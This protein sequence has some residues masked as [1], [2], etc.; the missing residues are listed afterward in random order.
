MFSLPTLKTT[1]QPLHDADSPKL[2]TNLEA[3]EK[4]EHRLRRRAV[5][6]MCTFWIVSISASFVI[7][8]LFARKFISVDHEQYSDIGWNHA[9]GL[10][11]R[12][13][14]RFD[15]SF[16]TSNAFM[17][18]PSIQLDAAWNRFTA[19]KWIDG[20]PVVLSVTEEEMSRSKNAVSPDTVAELGAENGGGRMATLEMFHQLHCLNLLRKWTYVDYYKSRDMAWSQAENILRDH[21]DHC[22]NILRQVLMCNGDMGLVMFHWVRD[23]GPSPYP[24]FSTMHQC[25]DPVAILE[26]AEK[27]AAPMVKPVTKTSVPHELP[28]FP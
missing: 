17:G 3:L 5:I 19:G 2:E 6:L 9:E 26:M 13:W 11:R 16:N 24:D 22:I 7:G 4:T 20:T 18:P 1:Y 10:L 12:H 15:G 14:H 8:C 21:T 28:T 23:H 27:N 25:R